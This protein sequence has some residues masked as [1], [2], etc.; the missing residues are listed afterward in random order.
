[1]KKLRV[2]SVSFFTFDETFHQIGTISDR[3]PTKVYRTTQELFDHTKDNMQYDTKELAKDVVGALNYSVS[4]SQSFP[5]S[6][7]VIILFFSNL[8]DSMQS[9]EQLKALTNI[10]LPKNVSLRIYA[11]SGIA[12][13]GTNI[14]SSQILLAEKS[15]ADF[16]KSKIDGD[17]AIYT[18]YGGH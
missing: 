5:S 17:V 7:K 18:I 12:C 4:L 16:F 11:S 6:D 8:R 1:M 9:K 10:Q 13:L 2:E 14:S 3:R 15:Y